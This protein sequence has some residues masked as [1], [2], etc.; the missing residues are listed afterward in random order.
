MM[1]FPPPASPHNPDTDPVVV[2]FKD[3]EM[4][5]KGAMED[6]KTLPL[7]LVDFKNK[8]LILKTCP[9]AFKRSMDVF[10]VA[11]VMLK[12]TKSSEPIRG[13]I[14]IS[15]SHMFVVMYWK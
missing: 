8:K 10:R 13:M 14:K 4:P 3:I 7:V 11:Q 2:Q 1:L 15:A 6:W 12:L 5:G 9:L